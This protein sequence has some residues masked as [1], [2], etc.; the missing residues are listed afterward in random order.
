MILNSPSLVLKGINAKF[1]K[2][3]ASVTTIPNYEK[4]AEVIDSQ[5]DKEE[6]V[7]FDSFSGIREW[8]DK[9]DYSKFKTFY[10]Q[11]RNK[12]WQWGIPVDRFTIED[13][14]VN[15]LQPNIQK[16]VNEG[17]RKWQ[18]FPKK[19]INELLTGGAS[20]VAFDNTYF[21]AADRP[22]IKGTSAIN[23]IATG[24]GTSL[25]QVT[26]DFESAQNL[27][28]AMVSRDGEPFNPDPKWLVV[29]PSQLRT[30]FE[31]LQKQ[32]VLAAGTTNIWANTFEIEVNPYQAV[33][34][35]DWYLINMNA[36]VKPFIYQS[37]KTP[38]FEMKDENDSTVIK[39]FSN[40]RMNAGY[41][42]PM[43]IVFVNNA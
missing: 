39:Y 31:N 33:T 24:T 34:N 40:A 15:G 6:Y 41:G 21:F 43:A 29:I 5:S 26:A 27:I 14:A 11:I 12:A 1:A 16:F 37:R 28:Y 18:T 35:N 17:V 42:N 38:L 30:Q 10:Y 8:I 20:T 19:L 3:L 9:I 2:D 32:V 4:Y 22:N 36:V 25:A 7:F 23:N 13:S